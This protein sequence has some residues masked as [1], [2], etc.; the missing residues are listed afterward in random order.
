MS[1]QME[2]PNNTMANVATS[3]GKVCG[4][5]ASQADAYRQDLRDKAPFA[6]LRQGNQVKTFTTGKEYF[7]TLLAAMRKARKCIFIAGWQVNWDVDLEPGV[8]LIDVLHERV[9]SSPDFR[10]YVMPW[11]SP[12]VAVN[13]GDLDTMLAIFQLNAGRPH[14]Q[15]MCCPAGSQNDHEGVEAGFFS[16]HQ[17][18]V[19]ID[20]E[21]AYVGGIDLAYGRRD[22]NSF[23]LDPSGLR[24]NERYNPGIPKLRQ[25]S[26]HDPQCLSVTD[27]LMATLTSVSWMTG[28][29]SDLDAIERKV[30]GLVDAADRTFLRAIELA[31]KEA[32]AVA[33]GFVYVGKQTAGVAKASAEAAGDLI[34]SGANASADLVIDAASSISEQCAAAGVLD[35]QGATARL[36]MP[37]DANTGLAKDIQRAEIGAR[38]AWNNAV[39]AV[40]LLHDYV[41][42]AMRLKVSQRPSNVATRWADAER[43]AVGSYNAVIQ[44]AAG[45]ASK[46]DAAGNKSLEACVELAPATRRGVRAAKQTTRSAIDGTKAMASE[47]GGE[48]KSATVSVVTTAARINVLQ[49]LVLTQLQFSRQLIN[50]ALAWIGPKSDAALMDIVSS[51]HIKPQDVQNLIDALKRLLKLVYLMQLAVNWTHV[52]RHEQLLNPSVKAA[53]VGGAFLD[54]LQPRQPWQDVHCEIRGPSVYD[55]AMNFIGRWNANQKSY[56]SDDT[57]GDAGSLVGSLFGAVATRGSLVGRF[58]GGYAGRKF[59]EP[60]AGKVQSAVFIENDLIPTEPSPTTNE[61]PRGVA[62]RVLR[63]AAKKLVE[64]E[65]AAAPKGRKPK[66]IQRQNEIETQMVNLIRGATDF[67]YIEN[68]FFQSDFGKPSIDVFGPEGERTLSAP[69][70]YLMRQRGNRM[71]SA[72]TMLGLKDQKA[73]A[74]PRNKICLAL[75]ERIAEAI[76]YG[77]PFHVYLVLPEHPEG[78][79]DDI[80]IMGQIHWTMQS[81]VFGEL[82]LVNRVRQAIWAKANCTNIYCDDEWRAALVKSRAHTD[83]EAGFEGITWTK[84]ST[85]LTLLNMRNCQALKSAKGRRV[86]TEQI[87]VHSKLLIVDDRHVIMGSA[88]INDRSLDGGRDSEIAVM[89][90]DTELVKAPLRDKEVYVTPLARDLRMRLWRKHFAFDGGNDVVGSAEE[91]LGGLIE[92]PASSETIAAIRSIAVGNAVAYQSAFDFI[93]RSDFPRGTGSGIWPPLRGS[94]GGSD[95]GL[96]L[97]FDSQKRMP[98]SLDYWSASRENSLVKDVMGYLLALPIFW[99]GG[100]NNHPTG[101]SVKVLTKAPAIV[102]SATHG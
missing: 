47:V 89:L 68:Q 18:L 66:I 31:K 98:F 36:A 11:M 69:M 6:P 10:V 56:L 63:S 44:G 48:I 84:W 57:L 16:H 76:R 83:G 79:L 94:A 43:S 9:S 49:G 41:K 62:V 45:A 51:E 17:K 12:K 77:H 38:Q 52:N 13:T 32:R 50:N 5:A 93:P 90:M 7:S 74:L 3:E 2:T 20:N 86:C 73:P 35:L 82:S 97:V 29:D 91:R 34:K 60:L 30:R 59:A 95:V 33:D 39:D 15:A 70:R 99:T 67:I 96:S 26:S 92:R 100:E 1:G 80:T 101:M 8:R 27:L 40:S 81:L 65:S 55:V 53:P 28:G 23:S 85:Y 22:D 46:V 19:V 21:I 61:A 37:A 42:P 88:N 78:R 75:G 58:A 54:D 102:Q 87:Y 71:T 64:Q 25:L 14:I 24:Y 4:L 72:L